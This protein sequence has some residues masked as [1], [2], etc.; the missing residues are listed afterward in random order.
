MDPYDPSNLDSI[1]NIL[2][3]IYSKNFSTYS[4]SF[5][6]IY[7]GIFSII[8]LIII[9]IF[10]ILFYSKVKKQSLNFLV[11]NEVKNADKIIYYVDLFMIFIV[12]FFSIL[13]VNEIL[14]IFESNRTILTIVSIIES[15]LPILVNLFTLIILFLMVNLL[16]EL[17][18]TIYEKIP[19]I[20]GYE[21][22]LV[23]F[24]SVLIPLGA[25]IIALN[26]SFKFSNFEKPLEYISFIFILIAAILIIPIVFN[27][28]KSILNSLI[29]PLF[30]TFLQPDKINIIYSILLLII[31]LKLVVNLIGLLPIGSNL[32]SLSELLNL[33]ISILYSLLYYT[34]LILG[35]YALFFYIKKSGGTI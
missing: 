30:S 19:N 1:S 18:P 27:F 26:I 31:V 20:L 24:L 8:E 22:T 3:E 34:L 23:S 7:S 14:K 21:K 6:K 35:I 33:P 5:P 4:L 15:T 13:I 9:F 25:A 10:F 32:S 12:S 29:Y 17:L 2:E 16:L 28:L 11:N